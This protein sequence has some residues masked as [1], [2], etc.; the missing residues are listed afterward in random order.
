MKTNGKIIV[1]VFVIAVFLSFLGI[2]IP[3][4][5]ASFVSSLAGI[6]N[7][8]ISGFSNLIAFIQIFIRF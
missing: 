8:I 6:I 7:A 4:W 5:L 3:D 1:S 2:P